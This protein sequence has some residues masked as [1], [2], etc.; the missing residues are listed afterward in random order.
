MTV[1]PVPFSAAYTGAM[2]QVTVTVNWQDN[3]AG[4]TLS[5]ARTNITFVSQYGLQQYVY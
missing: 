5:F 4:R 2:A 1:G 3:H